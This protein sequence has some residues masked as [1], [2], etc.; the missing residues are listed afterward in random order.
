MYSSYSFTT[1]ALDGGELQRQYSI[2]FPFQRR[3]KCKAEILKEYYNK[4]LI[5]VLSLLYSVT[6]NSL[7]CIKL[8]KYVIH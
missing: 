3:E 4:H 5:Q 7:K 2:L 1:S 6:Y 8:E